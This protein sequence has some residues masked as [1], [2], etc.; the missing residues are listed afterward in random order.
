MVRKTLTTYSEQTGIGGDGGA[1]EF[2]LQAA[3]KRDP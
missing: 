2:E 3:V 1:V